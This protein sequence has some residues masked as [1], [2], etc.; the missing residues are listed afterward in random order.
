MLF[1]SVQITDEQINYIRSL[2]LRAVQLWTHT[3]TSVTLS[4]GDRVSRSTVWECAFCYRGSFE[5]ALKI[6]HEK[7]CIISTGAREFESLNEQFI[8]AI[9][10]EQ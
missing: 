7:S 9:H 4:D 6:Q 3:S 1:R 10:G 5:G 8:K 2:H